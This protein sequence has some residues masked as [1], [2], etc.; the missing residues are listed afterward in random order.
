MQSASAGFRYEESPIQPLLTLA[1]TPVRVDRYDG[2][3]TVDYAVVAVYFACVLLLGY[4][5][6][7]RQKSADE[8]FLAGRKMP[9]FVVGLSMYASLLSTIAYL[10][11]PGEFIKNGI[12]V[13]GR[14]MHVP[15]SVTVAILVL[16]P[17]FM[18]KRLTS[19]Y[20]YLEEK[21]GLGARM[22]GST[23][24]L[25]IRLS[26]M[27]M[28]VYTAAI[29]MSKMADL[30]FTWVVLGVGV[31]A[32]VYTVLGGMRAV[33]WTDLVQFIILFGGL[34]F[35]IGYVFYDTGTGPITWLQDILAADHEPQPFFRLDPY[36]RVSV[37]GMAIYAFIWWVSTCGSDQLMVQRYLATGSLRAA[38]RSILANQAADVSVGIL[39]GLGGIALYSYYKAQ[40]PG[41]PDEVFPHFIAHTLPRGLAGL[42]VAALF[43]TA[44]AA[45]DSSMHG[46]ATVLTVDFVGRFRKKPLSQ[47]ALLRLARLFTLGA[48]IYAVLFCLFLNTIPEGSRGNIFDLTTRIIAYVIGTLGGMFVAAF[49]RFRASGTAMVLG[50]FLGLSAGFYLSL[51]HWFQDHPDIF[52]YVLEEGQE[53]ARWEPLPDTSNAIGSKPEGNRFVLNGDGVAPRHADVEKTPEGWSIRSLTG[54]AEVRVNDRPGSP[55]VIGP[56]DMVTLGSRRLLVRLK[57]V[58]WMWPL[59]VA[60]MVTLLSTLFL[61]WLPLFKRRG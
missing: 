30:P 14:Q 12:G 9:W 24:F 3:Q 48:G 52:L 18:R 17:F 21:Y 5:F 47:S 32:V 13:W 50:A 46:V 34:L 11:E 28:I 6:S 36:V 25:L 45:L 1:T 60:F 8:Y 51:G 7:K 31:I 15:F 54:D 55:A 4:Y 27:G 23:L 33:M 56:D 43:S 61:G 22:F 26:M 58:S 39:L 38:R 57:A 49:L 16:V 59:P 37:L 40:L 20:E 41:A 19:A 2:L 29:A 42:V 44:M 35:T 10:S 53:P